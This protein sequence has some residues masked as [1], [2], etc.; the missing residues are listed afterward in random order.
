MKRW[1]KICLILMVGFVC[2]SCASTKRI[3]V[4][5]LCV[6]R[7]EPDP[8]Q[9]YQIVLDT[10]EDLAIATR[11]LNPPYSLETGWIYWPPNNQ[12]KV[13]GFPLT[14]WKYRAEINKDTVTLKAK[15]RGVSFLTAFVFVNFI[16]APLD[17]IEETLEENLK[18]MAIRV[19]TY[20]A[21]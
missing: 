18:N 9:V 21:P 8:Y 6:A 4:P 17:W 2:I 11:S 10:F 19:Q 20:S 12:T 7:E 16:P 13:L 15:G 5:P 14:W 1:I 3:D